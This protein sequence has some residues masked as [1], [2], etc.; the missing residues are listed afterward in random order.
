MVGLIGLPPVTPMV[1]LTEL[2]V[3]F[4]VLRNIDMIREFPPMVP[5]LL[6]AL[7]ILVTRTSFP[8]ILVRRRVTVVLTVTLLPP[9]I[10]VLN[11]WFRAS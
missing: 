9:E 4:P 2:L 1:A 11:P 10:I 3:R 6:G 8:L 5:K 7:L